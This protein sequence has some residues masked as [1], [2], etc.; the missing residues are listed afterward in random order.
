[1]SPHPATPHP[2]VHPA[3]YSHRQTDD[4]CCMPHTSSIRPGQLLLCRF[5]PSWA[6]VISGDDEGAFGWLALNYQQ[7]RLRPHQ[8]AAAAAAG[9]TAAS[10]NITSLGALDLGGS[11]LQVTF[12]VP[13]A[14]SSSS[15]DKHGSGTTTA[16]AAPPATAA[17]GPLPECN[18]SVAGHTFQLHLHSF[19]QYGLNEAYDRSITLLLQQQETQ[20]LQMFLRQQ[21]QHEVLLQQPAGG[22][23][24]GTSDE[25]TVLV[26]SASADTSSNASSDGTTRSEH[27]PSGAA[28]GAI[29]HDIAVA[30]AAGVDADPYVVTTDGTAEIQL[31][32]Q[33]LEQQRQ[34]DLAVAAA[35][36]FHPHEA[37]AQVQPDST[38]VSSSTAQVQDDLG[39]SSSV[40]SSGTLTSTSSSSAAVDSSSVVEGSSS[41][42]GL[43]PGAASTNVVQTPSSAVQADSSGA[44]QTSYAVQADGSGGPTSPG[45]RLQAG[46]SPL[47]PAARRR[48]SGLVR[49]SLLQQQ[50]VWL[51]QR[52]GAP[53]AQRGQSL[54]V[55]SHGGSAGDGAAAGASGASRLGQHSHDVVL[56]QLLRDYLLRGDPAVAAPAAAAVGINSSSSAG[57]ADVVL[58]PA[59]VA[60]AHPVVP[61]D[62]GSISSSSSS[63][64]SKPAPMAVQEERPGISATTSSSSSS[65]TSQLPVVRH[66][67]LHE[68]YEAVYTRVAYAG[69]VPDPPQVRLPLSYAQYV[70]M[71]LQGVQLYTQRLVVPLLALYS[72]C[73]RQ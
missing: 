39:S 72:G 26:P 73:Y 71:S 52:L 28:A 55:S 57:G 50:L 16:A 9:S 33:H 59:A 62:V 65:S 66:P 13:H 41:H 10:S 70:C 34:A 67:C 42:G 2:I 58:S 64:V 40:S 68:G 60:E 63:I 20:A 14:L 51:E 38:G 36:G 17:V 15:S 6:R 35:A 46:T 23:S 53:A 8:P 22:S 27:L 3:L 4:T 49:R 69:F 56:R 47:L 37:P 1:M 25:A 45:L 43:Q 30:R 5:E 48:A 29:Q 54:P 12:E 24:N 11:S 21:G 18:I 19:K 31:A 44:V 32:P 7:G 61:V